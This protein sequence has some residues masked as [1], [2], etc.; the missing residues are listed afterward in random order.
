[1]LE[2]IANLLKSL[3]PLWEKLPKRWASTLSIAFS[4]A[5]LFRVVSPVVEERLTETTSPTPVTPVVAHIF[6]GVLIF[7]MLMPVV[8]ALAYLA[9]LIYELWRRK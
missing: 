9:H 1:M 4:V 8:I 2:P 7:V 3:A 6:D 5:I